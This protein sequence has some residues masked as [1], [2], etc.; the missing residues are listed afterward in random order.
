MIDYHN[1]SKLCNHA[2]GETD[3]YVNAAIKKGIKEIGFSDHFPMNYQPNSSVP[4][5]QIT[6]RENE[7]NKYFSM[8][9]NARKK[10]TNIIIRTGFEVD[11][12]K[13]ENLF[14]RKYKKLYTEVDYIIGSVHFIDEIGFDQIEFI[15]K[16]DN[17]ELLWTKY[18][19]L[20]TEFIDK[21][22]TYIDIIGH[23]DLPKKFG[24]FLSDKLLPKIDILL[25]LIKEKNLTIEVNTAGFDSNVEEQ[26]PS[27][28]ILKLIYKKNIDITMGSDSHKPEDVARHFDKTVKLLKQIGFSKLSKFSMH[29]K[30][31]IKL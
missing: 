31:Y 13:K 4:I 8:I 17:A 2:I 28:K 26:Y 3:E 18:I 5:T 7:I 27:A 6:M 10:F 19:S 16:V 9:E 30:D 12:F 29:K 1:H 15:N 24:F 11:Y 14:F 25:D 20:L 21:Y 22:H 23:L